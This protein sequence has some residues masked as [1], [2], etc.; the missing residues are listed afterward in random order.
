M[1][2]PISPVHGAVGAELRRVRLACGLTQQ[3]VS[4]RV[5]MHRTYLNQVEAGSRNVSLG[6]LAKLARVLETS[7]S[8]VVGV[9]DDLD[10]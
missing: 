9:A 10:P 8:S 3:E 5:G 1:P 2:A 4:N 6:I 7:L